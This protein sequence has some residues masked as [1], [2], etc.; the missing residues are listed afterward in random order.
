[1]IDEQGIEL[2]AVVVR[3]SYPF[4]GAADLGHQAALGEALEIDSPVPAGAIRAQPANQLGEAGDAAVLSRATGQ[5][6]ELIQVGVAL[7]K[8]SRP[9][10]GDPPDVG[11]GQM[12]AQGAQGG[13]RVDDVA[14]GA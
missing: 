4:A 9:G 5:D 10:V 8:V 2:A 6:D 7:Q 14:D 13:Q 12:L 1:M 3:K 11:M